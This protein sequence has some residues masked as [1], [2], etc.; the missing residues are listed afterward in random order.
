[1]YG[2]KIQCLMTKGGYLD[3]GLRT[4]LYLAARKLIIENGKSVR[5]I[6]ENGEG[7]I[8]TE[9]KRRHVASY[10]SGIE[11]DAIVDH[12]DQTIECR[13]LVNDI[14]MPTEDEIFGG[15]FRWLPVVPFLGYPLCEDEEGEEWKR[16]G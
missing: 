13:F 6:E 1:M 3:D 10:L 2:N 14:G 5:F 12:G 15:D 16:N 7:M 11:F 4:A 8:S 9:H